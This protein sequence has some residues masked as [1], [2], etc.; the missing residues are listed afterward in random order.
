MYQNKLST[1]KRVVYGLLFLGTGFA[2]ILVSFGIIQLDESTIHSPMWVI[3]LC[4]VVFSIAGLM[5]FLGEKSRFSNL[6]AAILTLSFGSIGAWVALFAE[7]SGFSGGLPF[8]SNGTNA[9][10]ARMM[11]GAGS[12]ICFAIAVYAIKLQLKQKDKS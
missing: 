6:L 9:I 7:S 11:F 12:L 4:G 1:N 10:L 5:V 3:G 8:I 2:F